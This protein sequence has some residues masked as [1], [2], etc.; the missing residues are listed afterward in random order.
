MGD[1]GWMYPYQVFGMLEV[2]AQ[3]FHLIPG[4]I[5]RNQNG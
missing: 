5:G 3:C 2:I 1:V 4:E